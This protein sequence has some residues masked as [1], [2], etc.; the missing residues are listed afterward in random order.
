MSTAWHFYRL[1][2]GHFNGMR[3]EGPEQYL[4]PNIPPGCGAITGVVD[5][6]SQRVDLESG[7][8]VD[9][10]PP[11]PADDEFRTFAWDA[12]LRRWIATPTAAALA[13]DAR[14]ERDR[15]LT[16]CDWVTARS[17]DEGEPVS[18]AWAAY[19]HALREV[20]EQA[21]FPHAIDWPVHP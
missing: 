7:A 14:A 17:I 21:G 5:A 8:L 12:Q 3:F 15:L 20:P 13:R 2:D 1:S 6:L 18:A 16:A 11:A 9:W 4:E 19:R 10:Q